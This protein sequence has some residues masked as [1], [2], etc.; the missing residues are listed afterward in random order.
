M[1]AIFF[2]VIGAAAMYLY[3]NPGDIDGMI[4]MGKT[5]VNEGA[6]I[7]KEATND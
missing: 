7:V 5:V 6:T 1:K 3:L 2:I 4:D